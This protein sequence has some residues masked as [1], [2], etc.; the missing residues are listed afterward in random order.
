[1][2]LP[3]RPTLMC[4]ICGRA[5]RVNSSKTDEHG[6]AVHEQCYVAK[7]ALVKEYHRLGQTPPEVDKQPG[8]SARRHLR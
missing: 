7:V 5:V 2:I 6:C 3:F 1:M 8:R 4:W